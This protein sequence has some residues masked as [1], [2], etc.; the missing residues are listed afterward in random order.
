M[1]VRVSEFVVPVSMVGLTCH[2]HPHS[3][4]KSEQNERGESLWG[5]H[6]VLQK[7]GQEEGLGFSLAIAFHTLWPRH[8]RA[9]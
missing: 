2:S 5:E 6:P 8:L 1:Q 7:N 3:S 4:K 9:T